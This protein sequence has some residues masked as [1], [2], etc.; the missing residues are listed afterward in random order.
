MNFKTREYDNNVQ[1][2]LLFK[3]C[4]QINKIHKSKLDIPN[5]NNKLITIVGAFNILLLLICPIQGQEFSIRIEDLNNTINLCHLIGMYRT[6][7][8]YLLNI[9]SF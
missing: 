9:Y 4:M 6:Q 3:I 8:Q 2:I 1:A 5:K 7:H